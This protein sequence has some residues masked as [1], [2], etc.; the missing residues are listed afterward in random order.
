[1]KNTLLAILVAAALPLTVAAATYDD[2]I[3]SAKL[4]DTRDISGMIQRGASVD[5]TDKEGNTLLIL[6]ARDEVVD[7]AQQG[8]Q[9]LGI[10]DHVA[11]S[12]S[13]FNAGRWTARC[14]VPPRAGAARP[15]SRACP[16][17]SG[18]PTSCS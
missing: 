14:E 15:P 17:A 1:M 16:C 3:N 13:G 5:T 9:S 10:S 2:L 6:A 4:G 11:S 12:P 7:V 18:R 8:I